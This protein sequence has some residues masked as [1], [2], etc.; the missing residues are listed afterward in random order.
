MVAVQARRPVPR[1]VMRQDARRLHV[2]TGSVVT[3][4]NLIRKVGAPQGGSRDDRKTL[5]ASVALRAWLTD[6]DGASRGYALDLSETGARF[7]GMS[8]RH[9]AGDLLLAKIEIDPKDAA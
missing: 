7:G 9:K 4:K 2:V 6:D 1:P 5:R 3:A 8:T